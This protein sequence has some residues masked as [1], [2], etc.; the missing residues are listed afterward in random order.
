MEKI[1]S[2][3]K[4]KEKRELWP[5]MVI[6]GITALI[7]AWFY[8]RPEA[9]RYFYE[10]GRPWNY[11]KLIAN[12]D[13]PVHPSEAVIKAAKDSLDSKFVPVYLVNQQL[14]DTVIGGFPQVP[15]TDF[16]ER[17]ARLLRN[18]Y[19]RGVVDQATYDKIKDGELPDVRILDVN[20]L[21]ESST[22]NFLSPR[23]VYARLD[24]SIH[25]PGLRAYMS[26]VRLA[27]L[28]RPNITYSATESKRHYDQ[29]YL[30]LTADRGVIQ[31]GQTIIDKGQIITPQDYTNIKT[32]EDMLAKS[33]EKDNASGWILWLGQ[34]L[35][36]LLVL[37]VFFVYLVIYEPAVLRQNKTVIFFMSML[38]VFFLIMAGMSVLSPMGVY[39][40][41]ITIVP[42]LTMVFFNG[43]LAFFAAMT[44][45][46]L[47][48]GIT[49]F[50]LEF[51]F[52]QFTGCSAA[53]FS[54]RDLTKRS[55][56]LRAS[57]FIA[58]AYLLSYVALEAMLNGEIGSISLRMILFLAINSLLASLCYVLMIVNEKIFGFCSKF[59]L[60]ELADTNSVLL[61]R[62]S[63]ECPGTF[64]HCLG[65]ST[66]AVDAAKRIGADVVLVRAG[67]LYHDIGKLNNPAFFTEN[68]RDINPH[69]LLPPERSARII[70][71]HVPD[72]VALASK[73]HLP[74]VLKDFILQHH[75]RGK[76]K[77]FYFNW[78][79][80]HPDEVPDDKLFT[81]P[82]PNPRTTETSILM[83]ADAV[84]AASRSLKS[85]TRA[86]IEG[87]VNK[88]ID[89]QIADG[90]FRESPLEFKDLPLIKEAFIKRL[91]TMYHS[92]VSY[93]E[94]P[95]NAL[96]IVPKPK[97]EPDG[98][99]KSDESGTSEN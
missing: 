98:S 44:E 43:R 66:L 54:L 22:A 97:E 23:E 41:P 72:G 90:L 91:L 84:E 37:A 39:L 65:V 89:T 15:G 3:K 28:M 47:C 5:K 52:L 73:Y 25:D 46:M 94:A 21:S 7:I 16:R 20:V 61:R 4:L 34:L 71:N 29:A 60:V 83:M 40:V 95:K 12:F 62:L 31:Q 70:I 10:E 56:M 99:D 14:A 76:A 9:N 11:T 67:A 2:L 77:Y 63:E 45:T 48:A 13:V 17:L 64:Q 79:K 18:Y 93:P 80:L 19:S 24:S 26:S 58:L 81:Y 74:E 8:P 42:I 30:T 27:E 75:G 87:L 6:V 1:N 69:D 57:F 88:I 33:A 32:Y 51:I 38:L 68:Q 92:R 36:V 86:D 49:N 85:Y 59:T 35:Y 78:C 53:V 55:D 82:G 96:T 50:P